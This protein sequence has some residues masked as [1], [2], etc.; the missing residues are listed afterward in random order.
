MGPVLSKRGRGFKSS[1]TGSILFLWRSRETY[2]RRWRQLREELNET[3]RDLARKERE[4]QRQE[5]EIAALERENELLRIREETAR[6]ETRPQLP[7]DPAVES[8]KAALSRTER[9]PAWQTASPP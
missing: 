3:K 9:V 1:L 2:R 7:E 4:S 6:K 5:E 8:S